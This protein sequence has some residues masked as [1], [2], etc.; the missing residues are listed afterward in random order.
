[1]SYIQVRP[2]FYE[3]Y[4]PDGPWAPGAPGWS[5]APVPM[6]G[7][8]PNLRGPAMLA[9]HGLGQ[10]PSRAGTALMG[11]AFAAVAIGVVIWGAKQIGQAGYAHNAGSYKIVRMF[12]SGK[13]RRTVKRGLTLEQA[14]AHCR[15]PET[16]SSTA[17]SAKAKRMTRQH[18]RWFDGYEEER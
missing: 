1:M 15:D 13:P 7:N 8:N 17:T 3:M 10:E 14:Q 4:Q 11:L 5:R 2:G 16:S 12:E 6:W 18:G 9:T